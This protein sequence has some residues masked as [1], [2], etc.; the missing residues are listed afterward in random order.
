MK[1]SRCTNSLRT[2]VDDEHFSLTELAA[3]HGYEFTLEDA[4]TAW[5]SLRT[6]ELDDLER[7]VVKCLR[8]YCDKRVNA[9]KINRLAAWIGGLMEAWTQVGG[10]DISYSFHRL[11]LF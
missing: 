9:S 6:D 11:L 7:E 3:E 10:V 1:M 4:A 2:A 8:A 5:R